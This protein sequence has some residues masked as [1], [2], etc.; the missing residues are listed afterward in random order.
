MK[1]LLLLL[2]C[3]NASAS[4]RSTNVK[5]K[6]D[7]QEGYPHGRKGFVVDHVCA[8]A[9]GGIDDVK[10][11]QYQTIEEGHKKDRVELT[12]LGKTLYCNSLNSLSIRTVFNCKD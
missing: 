7:V 5:H 1:Y 6:F 2:I 8:L 3:F 12:P 9:V 10:N 11:M 4:C